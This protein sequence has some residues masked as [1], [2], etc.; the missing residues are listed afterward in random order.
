VRTD[1]RANAQRSI[2]GPGFLAIRNSHCKSVEQL[3]RYLR[4]VEAARPSQGA[5]RTRRIA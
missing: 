4:P 5:S 1:K 2:V 3:P